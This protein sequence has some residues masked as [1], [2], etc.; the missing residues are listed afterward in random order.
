MKGVSVEPASHDDIDTA[1]SGDLTQSLRIPPYTN[2]G[3]ID[4]GSPAAGAIEVELGNGYV[5]VDETNIGRRK[6]SPHLVIVPECDFLICP[7][8]GRPFS[9]RSRGHIT[10]QMLMKLGMAQGIGRY[11][12]ADSLDDWI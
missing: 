12:T 8:G 5:A 6:F 1:S 4:D 7:S 9:V 3:G 2:R 10:Q 11:R